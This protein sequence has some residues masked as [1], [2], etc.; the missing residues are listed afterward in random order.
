MHHFF[1]ER[2][3]KATIG[4]KLM[5]E[6][7][8]HLEIIQI[9]EIVLSNLRNRVKFTQYLAAHSLCTTQVLLKA[10]VWHDY[11][12]NMELKTVSETTNQQ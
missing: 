5:F 11:V 7:K 9:P 6:N 2:L 10:D 3:E 8:S 1:I 12:T 4:K